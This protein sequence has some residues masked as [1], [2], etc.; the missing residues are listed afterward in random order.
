MSTHCALQIEK[1][2]LDGQIEVV[3]PFSENMVMRKQKARLLLATYTADP[4]NSVLKDPITEFRLGSGNPSTNSTG[5]ETGLVTPIVS[6]YSP[7]SLYSNR[8]VGDLS[9]KSV[10]YGLTLTTAQLNGETINEAGLFARSGALFSLK[11]FPDI[12]KDGTFALVFQWK[13]SV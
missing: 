12:A 11:R 5:G 8:N 1:H 7:T 10:T 9:S 13:L 2:Y 6:G 4:T 3:L